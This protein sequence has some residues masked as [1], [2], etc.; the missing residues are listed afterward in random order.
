MAALPEADVR[1]RARVLVTTGHAGASREEMTTLPALSLICCIGTGYE[2]V[3]LAAA[4][5]RGIVVVHG[6]GTNAGAVADHA[7]ALLL[8]AMRDIPRFDASA[9]RG[10]W[11]GSLGARPI[12]SGKRLGLIGMGGIGERVARRGAAFDMEISYHT[13]RPRPDLP[14]PH[15]PSALALAEAVDLLV[16]AAPGGAST[17]HMVDAAVLKALGPQGFL[18]NVGRGSIVDTAAL[19]AALREGAIAGAGLDVFEDEPEIPADLRALP[20]L[21]MTPHVGAAAPEVQGAAAELLRRN[22]ELFLE[23]QSV[24]TPV[25]E[26]RERHS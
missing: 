14:W 10:A 3:D 7:F 12:P 25:P 26:M 13:R 15:F 24:L 22:V 20:N 1:C 19:V 18:V 21:V 4:R 8:A 5:E 2:N 17:H 9:R 23:G 16:V 11:R 6:A